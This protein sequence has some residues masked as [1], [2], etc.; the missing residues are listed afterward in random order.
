MLIDS[1]VLVWV[2][3]SNRKAIA[4]VDRLRDR[5]VSVVTCMELFR[6]ARDKRE[7][8]AICSFLSDAGFRVMPLTEATG[9]RAY[10]YVERHVLSIALSVPDALIAATAV[11][12]G[13]P[14]LTGND[15][16]F[17]MLEELELRPFRP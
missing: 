15:K 6:G 5:A 11:E 13:L 16:H 9:R 2:L 10:Q 17:R 14:L 7:L 3:R 12:S 1:D 8:Q 4:T